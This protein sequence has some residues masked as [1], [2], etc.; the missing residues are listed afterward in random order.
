M[1]LSLAASRAPVSPSAAED[2]A[3]RHTNIKPEID[4]FLFALLTVAKQIHFGITGRQTKHHIERAAKINLPPVSRTKVSP[5][6][7]LLQQI[8]ISVKTGI[9]P[10]HTCK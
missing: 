7:K 4:Y 3:P 8:F 6:L 9:L 5:W 10:P 1:F 2:S